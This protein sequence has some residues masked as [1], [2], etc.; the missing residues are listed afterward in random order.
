[1]L[2][3][4]EVKYIEELKIINPDLKA[5]RKCEDW[6][7]KINISKSALLKNINY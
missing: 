2:K 1:M 4:A 3:I 7:R 5:A 6:F